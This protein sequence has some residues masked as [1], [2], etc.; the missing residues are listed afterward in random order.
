MTET[1]IETND[2]TSDKFAWKADDVQWQGPKTTAQK[3]ADRVQTPGKKTA[4]KTE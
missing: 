4:P 1:P 2:K 3:L